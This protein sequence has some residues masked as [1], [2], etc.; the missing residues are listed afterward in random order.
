MLFQ[1]GEV[2]GQFCI[3]TIKKQPQFLPTNPQQEEEFRSLRLFQE[4][5]SIDISQYQPMPPKMVK[6]LFQPRQLAQGLGG[7]SE[8]PTKDHHSCNS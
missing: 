3:A 2:F 7:D 8:I 5:T 6:I 4:S 1:R